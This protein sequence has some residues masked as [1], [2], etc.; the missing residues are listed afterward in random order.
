MSEISLVSKETICWDQLKDKRCFC[1]NDSEVFSSALV[2][3]S[4]YDIFAAQLDIHTIRSQQMTVDEKYQ[5]L[6]HYV[7]AYSDFGMQC[8][9]HK[10]KALIKMRLIRQNKMDMMYMTL[11][12]F[13]RINVRY[14]GQWQKVS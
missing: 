6:I 11:W 7:E 1:G 13:P 4:H 2:V 10:Y 5:A 9:Y 3:N 14:R 8:T 12:M